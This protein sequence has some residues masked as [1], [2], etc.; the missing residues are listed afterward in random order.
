MYKPSETDINHGLENFMTICSIY[1]FEGILFH[2][3]FVVLY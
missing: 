3:F 1:I 2:S